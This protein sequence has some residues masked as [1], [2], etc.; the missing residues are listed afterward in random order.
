MKS[1]KEYLIES[2]Q[3]YEFKIKLAGDHEDCV[4]K[5]KSALKQ[6]NVESVSDVKR[7]P[8]QETQIDFP[9]HSNINVTV[10]DVV[11][12]YPTTSLQIRNLVAEALNL[13]HTCVKVRNIKEQE[14]DELN[15]QYDEK[16]GEALLGTDYEKSMHQD[17]VG[18]KQKMNLLKELNKTK[19]VGE[20]YT[21]VNDKLLAKKAPVSKGPAATSIEKASSSVIGSKKTA[22]GI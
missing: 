14:E 22:G 16:S 2:K 19:H 18:E 12:A 1:F 6:F 3:T 20:Q 10:C 8:I 11:C 4:D 15:H 9:E 13:T 5:I 17:L 21:G 7:T